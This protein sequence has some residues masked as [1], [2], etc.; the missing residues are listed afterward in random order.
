MASHS[1]LC[2]NT[3]KEIKLKKRRNSDFIYV[4]LDHK[5]NKKVGFPQLF[6]FFI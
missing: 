2:A 3:S 6:L 1:N 5:D 4:D